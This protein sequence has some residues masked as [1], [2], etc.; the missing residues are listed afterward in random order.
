MIA[1]VGK[2]NQNR[3]FQL[4]LVTLAGGCIFPLVYLRQN[5]EV[6]ILQSF[7][8]SAVDLRNIYS[9]MGLMFWITYIPSGW[10]ADRVQPKYL[11]S[12]SLAVTGLLGIWFSTY[13]GHDSLR[14]IF[15]GWGIS[16]G[17]TFWAAMLKAVAIIARPEEQ[18]RFFGMLDGGRGLV[19]AVLATIAISLFAYL[20]NSV[21]QEASE[22]LKRVIWFYISFV[23]I[24]VPLIFFVVSDTDVEA[25]NSNP[26]DIAVL[27]TDFKTLLSKQEIWLAAACILCGYQ[28]FWATYSFS[29]Y[30]QVN[31]GLSAVTVGSITVAKLW[32]RPIGA[33]AAGFLGDRF[34]REKV[35]A[36]LLFFSSLTLASL[37]LV[38]TQVGY[39]VLIG[40]VL[41]VGILTYGVRGVF[42]SILESC[43]VED[44]IKGLALGMLSF[45]G[46]APD[47]YQP[48]ISG[49]LLEVFP[50]RAGYDVYYLGVA[51]M[52]ILGVFAA[53]R[54]N[55]LTKLKKPSK[56]LVG[57]I[58]Q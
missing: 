23:L 1:S 57:G 53:L 26:L 7:G 21:G 5:F 36:L 16:T 38:S 37:T 31:F 3:Y 15:L 12:F 52:G 28:L 13:P 40:L 20:I 22:A 24:L 51:G 42:W 18:G 48:L 9:V 34:N 33:T 27:L 4:L 49:R 46:F 2:S 30:L 11:M 35:L 50:G 14:M 41:T 54:L 44:R 8:I 19:E 10:L 55:Y 45:L 43:D 25:Q 6:T 39:S 32:M 56:Q 47:F 17:L 58:G 29:A